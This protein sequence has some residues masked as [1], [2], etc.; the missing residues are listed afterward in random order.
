[1]AGGIRLGHSHAAVLDS[2]LQ[3]IFHVRGIG[4]QRSGQ[5]VVEHIAGEVVDAALGLVSVCGGQADGRQHGVAAVGA[6]EAIQYAHLTLTVHH[7]IVHGD[8]SNA[9]ISEFH[10]LN[11]VF[12]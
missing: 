11:G 10:A 2:G 1:M 4:S 12:A 5:L 7:F 6:V 9:D 3:L 8:I